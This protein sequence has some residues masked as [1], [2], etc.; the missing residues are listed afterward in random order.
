VSPSFSLRLL[1]T[2]SDA[3]LVELSR[4]GHEPAFEALVRR[5]RKPLLAY[6]RRLLL[7]DSLAE[8]ALQQALLRAWVA[9]QR[10]TEVRDVR[11]WL[12]RV[13]HN[14]ALD[15]LRR[16]RYDLCELNES[17]TG[18][19]APE[20]DLARRSAVRQA[21]AGIAALPELQREALLRTAVEGHSHEAVARQ[22]GLSH[23]AV[24][25]LVYRA[26][27]TL[28]A[29]ATAVVPAPV[30]H[31]AAG[32]AMRGVPL[33]ERL[34]ELA[35]G[36]TAGAALLKGGA[37]IVAAGAL[38][39]GAVVQ[40]KLVAPLWGASHAHSQP[41]GALLTAAGRTA[42]AGAAALAPAAAVG[43]TGGSAASSAAPGSGAGAGRRSP[44]AGG[45]H[46]GSAA[47]RHAGRGAGGLSGELR[48]LE[49]AGGHEGGHDGSAGHGDA[50]GTPGHDGTSQQGS[51]SHEGSG[52]GGRTDGGE[53]SQGGSTGG[54]SGGD[55]SSSGPGPSSGSSTSGSD[56]GSPSTG[57][58]GSSGGSGG[59][60][61]SDGGT[62][63][64]SG[65]DGSAAASSSSSGSTSGS[66]SSGDSSA[67]STST[68]TSG[69]SSSGATVDG[70]NLAPV[71]S[72][73]STGGY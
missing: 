36:G 6:C 53:T 8:D 68:T 56:T 15:A 2:Q 45:A 41:R 22:L 14:T 66:G 51:G 5:Y 24:R 32:Q 42:A 71:A 65:S 28:R 9:L 54:S 63:G 38:V 33:A 58:T 27:A 30:A 18:A 40:P 37:A 1:T 57:E 16:A 3:R 59:T 10:G 55:G 17:I 64:T 29:A 44:G 35:G 26:R 60:S 61:G 21:L 12:Y 23:E 49:G 25:G 69:S 19:G 52:S 39:T 34:G 47:E 50:A 43:A 72:D 11:A 62:S 4:R 48:P 46:D 20:E 13:V 67:K 70:S 73:A 31:W 7:P